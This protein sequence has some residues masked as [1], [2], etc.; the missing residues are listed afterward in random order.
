MPRELGLGDLRGEM[1]WE[2]DRNPSQVL[3]PQ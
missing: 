3:W 1:E 2:A